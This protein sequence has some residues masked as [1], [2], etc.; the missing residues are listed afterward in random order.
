MGRANILSTEGRVFQ[1]VSMSEMTARGNPKLSRIAV[2]AS[3]TELSEA[4]SSIGLRAHERA[5]SDRFRGNA[6]KNIKGMS[7]DDVR[8]VR[9]Y[10]NAV[11]GI[12]G[13]IGRCVNGWSSVRKSRS[14][15]RT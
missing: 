15:F 3:G 6:G 9:D 10:G 8:E 11:P 12:R 2:S 1:G 7:R 14:R 13:I 5:K 4:V